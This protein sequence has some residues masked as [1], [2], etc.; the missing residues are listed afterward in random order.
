MGEMR[1]AYSILVAKLERKRLL[2]RPRRSWNDNIG[3]D[4][5]RIGLEDVEWMHLAQD[6][7]HWRVCKHGSESSSSIKGGKFRDWLCEY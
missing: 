3:M 7:D 6:T 1:T 4:L 2:G 5:R